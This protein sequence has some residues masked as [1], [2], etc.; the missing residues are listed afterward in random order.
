MPALLSVFDLP[1]DVVSAVTK[2]K[3]RG[4]D[5]IETYSPAPFTEIDDAVDP[6]PSKVRIFTLV[7]GLTGVVLGFAMQIW[8]SLNW[9]IKIAGKPFASI[10]AYSI[11]GFELMVLLAGVLTLVGMLIFGKLYP[12]FA[13]DKA[14]SPRFSAEEFGVV[15]RCAERDVAE[16]DALLRAESAKEVS[17][18]EE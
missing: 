11:I 12:R 13:L 6:K 7:G 17:V 14:Y 4:F 8:M 2:L 16:V 18:V 10:P 3:K 5:D 15:V 9:P 1:D